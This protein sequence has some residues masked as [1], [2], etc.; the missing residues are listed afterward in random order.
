MAAPQCSDSFVQVRTVSE[1]PGTFRTQH[2]T[3][4]NDPKITRIKNIIQNGPTWLEMS[5][6][7]IHLKPT[8][9]NNRWQTP[10]TPNSNRKFQKPTFPEK[11]PKCEDPET[12]RGRR[13]WAEH[14]YFVFLD[15]SSF[16]VFRLQCQHSGQNAI[17]PFQT[18]VPI[19][20]KIIAL[21]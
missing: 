4:E 21:T 9:I 11:I 19:L 5:S 20:E 18:C 16:W 2:Q 7:S 13:Q 3:F 8:S 6:E 15:A 10:Q 14:L 17:N 1:G 12:R